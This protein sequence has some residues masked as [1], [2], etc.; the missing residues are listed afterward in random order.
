LDGFRTFELTR[1]I[2]PTVVDASSVQILSAST[3]VV[4]G[5]EGQ[6]SV[7]VQDL[8][9]N[10]MCASAEACTE[11]PLPT[12]V[13]KHQTGSTVAGLALF[14]KSQSSFFCTYT[15]T[16]AGTYTISLAIANR[17]VAFQP[18][19]YV[20]VVPNKADAKSFQ[21]SLNSFYV[22]GSVSFSMK[23]RDIFSNNIS[24][25]GE[26]IQVLKRF[27]NCSLALLHG[28]YSTC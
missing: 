18:T 19:P 14:D 21:F 13:L 22:V 3:S 12:V 20:D 6:F 4:A 15:A 9:G 2:A 24:V 10:R 17:T 11:P 1:K 28:S 5:A 23:A 8:F 26:S 16:V 27:I 25:G 7:R